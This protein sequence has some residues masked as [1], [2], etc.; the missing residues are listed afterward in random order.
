MRSNKAGIL[1]I[2]WRQE[3]TYYLLLNNEKIRDVI[4]TI[5]KKG[6]LILGRFSQERKEILD[7]IREK[8]R[9]LDYLP[10]LFDFEKADSKDF[11][12]TIK[13]LAGLSRFVI[14]DITDP[15]SIPKEL[16]ATVPDYQI[17]FIPILQKGCKPFAMFGDLNKYPW[18]QSILKYDSG[19][20]LMKSLKKGV[21]DRALEAEKDIQNK[22]NSLPKELDAKD[23]VDDDG[24]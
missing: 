23:Y 9:T 4:G 8:L 11:T 19:E 16:E 12:V 22:K 3:Y 20:E 13:I 21:I 6:V 14:A 10:M 2:C 1:I 24:L 15:S 7:T 17:P 18:M 5:A